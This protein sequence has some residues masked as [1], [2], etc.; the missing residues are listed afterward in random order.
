ML[1][2]LKVEAV[3]LEGEIQD[4]MKIFKSIFI[5]L[6]FITPLFSQMSSYKGTYQDSW[7]I[8]DILLNTAVS[9][10]LYLWN[11]S[12]SSEAGLIADWIK[13]S[14][15]LN[16]T[17]AI[18]GSTITLSGLLTADQLA[19][20]GTGGNY[21]STNLTIGGS[22]TI[23]LPYALEI[24]GRL[25]V[26]GI[27]NFD[28][29]I[30]WLGGGS[31]TT[32]SHIAD[33]SNPH[34]VLASQLTD[35]DPVWDARLATKTTD[36]LSE[37]T[38]NLYFTN[39][40]ARAA[41]SETITGIDYNSTS[42]VFS[43]TSGYVIPTTV[44]ETNW[45]DAYAK[46]V[47]TWNLPLTFASNVVTFNYN[48]TNFSLSGNDLI[49]N[50]IS[51]SPLAN[52]FQISAVNL[53]GT[54]VLTTPQ[55]LRT[56]A[57]PVFNKPNF[58]GGLNINGS[59]L[60]DASKNLSTANV[61]STASVG[62]DVFA[63]QTTGWRVDNN[64]V[65]DFRS[66]Y[67][68]ELHAKSF[69]ADLEQALAGGEIISKSVAK[70]YAD[71]SLSTDVD[72]ATITTAIDSITTP[73]DSLGDK[74]LIVESFGG[75]E[76]VQVFANDDMVRL[77]S[78][79][80]NNG[81]LIIA[82][83]WGSVTLDTTYGSSGFNTTLKTQA[84][85]FRKL[86]GSNINASSETL[87][88]DYGTP[89]D[90]IIESTVND[91]LGSPYIDVKTWATNPYTDIVVKAR[92]GN[93]AG[94]TDANFGALSGFGLYSSNVALTGLLWLNN[95]SGGDGNALDISANSTVT[96]INGN[97]TTNSTNITSNANNILLKANS[98]TTDSLRSRILTNESGI[99]INSD[100]VSIFSTRTITNQGDI[101]TNT[102]SITVNADSIT[103]HTNGYIHL[104]GNTIVDG[105]FTLNGSALINGSVT[106]N[107]LT[108][109]SLSA[110]TANLGSVTAGSIVGVSIQTSLT[111]KR[112]ALLSDSV[113]FY[114][115]NDSGYTASL[116][117]SDNRYG[118][119]LRL[120][121]YQS[122]YLGN[123]YKGASFS[124]IYN[125]ND[126]FSIVTEEPE[127]ELGSPTNPSIRIAKNIYP[128]YGVN[129]DIGNTILEIGS[130]YLA[131]GKYIEFGGGNV[132][133]YRSGTDTLK[134]DDNF[135]ALTLQ[136]NGTERI[137]ASGNLSNIG[138]ISS[139][140]ITSSS[141][142]T[143][144][145]LI[146]SG[147][148]KTANP[149]S[150]AGNWELGTNVTTTGL[151]LSTTNYIEVRINGTIYKLAVVN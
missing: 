6:L 128:S 11:Y 90:G 136:T 69:I 88:L 74:Q 42:G 114:S 85:T 25:R 72:W 144:T 101:S 119:Q 89:G 93:L 105:T 20:T 67:T 137:D 18:N 2:G 120:G 53:G 100:S 134:T 37:G 23:G 82:D 7:R 75:F 55:D 31:S 59:E 26:T 54:F 14:T 66:I 62:S 113:N 45:N 91:A 122:G 1:Q 116:S 124:I 8:N 68:D 103:L 149:S 106:T 29:T 98:T 99:S 95:G 92:Y 81:G 79:D 65:A 21:F 24:K 70:I 126:I 12:D 46:R 132:N 138:T 28:S 49:S 112:V 13:L 47:D 50:Q 33:T 27:A 135:T 94:I 43:L 51:A 44:E 22:P 41:I 39:A 61:Y 15:T 125:S 77:R 148:I 117:G 123:P 146:L 57:S 142:I 58:T 111:G 131:A 56:T 38:T 5:S 35:Y 76:T 78:F 64:G 87:A 40:R 143:G 130:I 145:S 107:K 127:D 97:I 71:F 60:S 133:L 3:L 118:L 110:L 9:D 108:V 19:I 147:N 109:D 104:T 141:T 73:I 86:Y 139:G 63:S 34:N 48:T 151:T 83:A 115:V 30:T 17:G 84:Y 36:S 16:V 102:S 52:G 129:P 150:G 140:A 10:T 80:R 121:R 4:K 96:S 32:N